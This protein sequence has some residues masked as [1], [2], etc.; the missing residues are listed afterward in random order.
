[1]ELVLVAQWTS[2]HVDVVSGD[3]FHCEH[4]AVA[5]ICYQP[6]YLRKHTRRQSSKQTYYK[7]K[8]IDQSCALRVLAIKVQYIFL[9]I[10]LLLFFVTCMRRVLLYPMITITL[11][12][13]PKLPCP[14]SYFSMLPY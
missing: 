6:V 5:R 7:I 12:P 4:D 10:K 11:F 9:R 3:V 14:L 1:M 8:Q 13:K 2:C